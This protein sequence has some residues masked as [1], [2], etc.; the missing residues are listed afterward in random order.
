MTLLEIILTGISLAMD[1][2]TIS[3]YKGLSTIK[4]KTKKAIKVGLYFGIFQALMPIIGYK[5][6]CIFK[7]KIILYNS[8]ISMILLITIGILM[9]KENN[10]EE[11]NDDLNFKEMILLSIA[12]SIDALVIGISFSFLKVKLISSSIIIGIITF[13]LCFIGFILGNLLNK[14]LGKYSNIIGGI[15]LILIGIKI[16]IQ[17]IFK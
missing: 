11:I 15:T 4:D 12:T 5:I 17:N 3:I 8:Y 16:F 7:E 10:D 1:A 6:G 14:K 13:I 9:I 2:F